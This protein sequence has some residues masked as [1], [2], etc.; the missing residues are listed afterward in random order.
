MLQ[1]YFIKYRQP[2]DGEILTKTYHVQILLPLKY[3]L[4]T[5]TD[6]EEVVWHS[7]ISRQKYFI[8]LTYSRVSSHIDFT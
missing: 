1:T 7:A 2:T 4:K 8:S 3:I 5:I 6:S